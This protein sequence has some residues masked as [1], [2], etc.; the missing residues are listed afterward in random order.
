MRGRAA[1]TGAQHRNRTHRPEAR[2]ARA[3]QR[4]GLGD[5]RAAGRGCRRCVQCWRGERSAALTGTQGRERARGAY[6]RRCSRCCAG[7][8]LGSRCRRRRCLAG[9]AASAGC[10][11]GRGSPARS[12]IHKCCGRG[13]GVHLGFKQCLERG[14]A[15][16]G[17]ANQ[18][19]T[20]EARGSGEEIGA[21]RA[22]VDVYGRVRCI[23]ESGWCTCAV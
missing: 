5:G 1:A 3:A 13:R 2:R 20:T 12:Q 10:A 9:R 14:S 11:A 7:S 6:R 18:S 23:G 16:P 15:P 17:N 19:P 21:E 22:R 8:P 4:H